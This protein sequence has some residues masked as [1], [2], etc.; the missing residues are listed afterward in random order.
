MWD[1]I[2]KPHKTYQTILSSLRK[3]L[4]KFHNP[5]MK[6]EHD[7]HTDMCPCFIDPNYQATN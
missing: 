3:I 5:A 6:H 2:Y 1:F 7:I 4:N